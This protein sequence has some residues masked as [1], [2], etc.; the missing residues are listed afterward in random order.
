M[1]IRVIVFD[2]DGTLVY[3]N[4]IK[5]EAYRPLFPPGA[6]YD[7]MVAQ[8]QDDLPAGTRFDLIRE[9][10]LREGEPHTPSGLEEKISTLANR[11]DQIASEGAAT[12]A[13]RE[14]ATATLSA[15]SKQLPLHLLSATWEPSL[16]KIIARRGWTQYFRSIR[17]AP[18]DKAVELLSIAAREK[19]RTEEILMVGDSDM[20]RSAAERAR[21]QYLGMQD[22]DTMGVVID[23]LEQ[24]R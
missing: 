1:N 15:L 20:D 10:L 9:M 3:S 8:V 11:Y 6:R 13:E 24:S 22:G 12:C 21:C 19:C 18:C 16:V 7:M 5:R 4:A 2:Y 17:G 23:R 14:G